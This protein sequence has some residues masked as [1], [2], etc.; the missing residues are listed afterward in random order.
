M[1][2]FRHWKED[3]LLREIELT[4]G[5]VALVDDEDYLNLVGFPWYAA[6][7]RIHWYAVYAT[8]DAKHRKSH[9]MHSIIM[10]T[11]GGYEVDH[12]D[13]NGLNNQRQ[14]LRIST[15]T[16]NS[17]NR[18]KSKAFYNRQLSSQYKGVSLQKSSNK[19]ISRIMQ[20]RRPIWL[21]IFEDEVDAARAYDTAAIQ[22]HGEFARLNFS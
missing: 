20:N 7:Q 1:A 11:P 6:K 19:W 12:R 2:A 8:G 4:Q 17:R 14:N 18:R 3:R 21:G 16:Q 15:A 5:K 13:G 10:K 9:R 22:Y